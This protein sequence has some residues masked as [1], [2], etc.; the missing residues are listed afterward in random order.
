MYGAFDAIVCL[1]MEE[2]YLST[3]LDNLSDNGI[4]VLGASGFSDEKLKNYFHQ[5][6]CFGMSDEIVHTAVDPVSGYRL[7]VACHRRK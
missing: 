6:F 7:F 2:A 4:A 1:N 5:V 3:L